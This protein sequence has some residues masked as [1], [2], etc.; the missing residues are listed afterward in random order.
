[1]GESSRQSRLR[2]LRQQLE[3]ARNDG[4]D[5]EVVRIESLIANIEREIAAE[6]LS[7]GGDGPEL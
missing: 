5:H 4:H 1:M 6:R 3:L 7:E 2:R